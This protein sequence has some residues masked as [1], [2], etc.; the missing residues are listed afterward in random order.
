MTRTM[1][2]TLAISTALTVM[3][4]SLVPGFRG[5]PGDFVYEA[6]GVRVMLPFVSGALVM[7]SVYG[8]LRLAGD[9]RQTK[10][11]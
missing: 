3:L 5:L 8:A 1:I 11:H 9:L 4:L 2:A 7:L 10:S 6:E